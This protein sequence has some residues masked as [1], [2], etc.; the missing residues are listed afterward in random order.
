MNSDSAVD[1][2]NQNLLNLIFS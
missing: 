2:G 1:A